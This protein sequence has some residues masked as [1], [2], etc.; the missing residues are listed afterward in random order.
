MRHRILAMATIWVALIPPMAGANGPPQVSAA[1]QRRSDPRLRFEVASVKR[2]ELG[3]S[4]FLLGFRNGRFTARYATLLWMV[5]TAYGQPERPLSEYQVVGGPSWLGLDRFDVE[6]TAPG[7]PHSPRG[8]FTAPVIAMVRN[9][10][11]ERFALKAHMESREYPLFAL[12]LA[13]PDGR[14]GPSMRRR[15]VECTAA[16]VGIAPSLSD[17]QACI[18]RTGPG[19]LMARGATIGLLIGGMSEL[20]GI[21]RIIVDRTGVTGTFDV[22]LRWRPETAPTAGVTDQAAAPSADVAALPSLF[23]ALEEQLGLKLERTTGPVDV[24]VIEHAE[25]PTAN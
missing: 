7:T 13:R 9:L 17:R 20:P 19:M 1:D 4:S 22:D 16:P 18:G 8:T 21:D 23:T 25:P 15:A 10:V 14:L 11:E 2:N 5:R 3:S 12:V 24:L 6:A